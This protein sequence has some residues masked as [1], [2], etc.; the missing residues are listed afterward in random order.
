MSKRINTFNMVIKVVLFILFVACTFNIV[1]AEESVVVSSIEGVSFSDEFQNVLS[2]SNINKYDKDNDGDLSSEELS[3][4]NTISLDLSGISISDW[5]DLNYFNVPIKLEIFNADFS[6]VVFKNISGN[7][8][9]FNISIK[10]CTNIEKLN[11]IDGFPFLTHLAI[12]SEEMVS[13]ESFINC[14]YLEVLDITAPEITK[15]EYLSEL[16]RIRSMQI[17]SDCLNQLGLVFPKIS[18][19]KE[20]SISESDLKDIPGINNLSLDSLYAYHNRISYVM[21]HVMNGAKSIDLRYND[22]TDIEWYDEWYNLYGLKYSK[23]DK[24]IDLRHNPLSNEAI[25]RILDYNYDLSR[26]ANGAEGKELI[27]IYNSNSP[28]RWL[29][30]SKLRFDVEDLSIVEISEGVV[31]YKKPGETNVYVYYDN[32]VSEEECCVIYPVKVEAAYE[33]VAPTETIVPTPTEV[34]D[35]VGDVNKD[36][37]IDAVDALIVLQMAAKLVEI[38]VDLADITEEGKVNAEDALLILKIAAK[39]E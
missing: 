30:L 31:K 21:P 1:K 8:Y 6:E 12:E 37:Y 3:Q 33:T 36:G 27:L 11:S 16:E 24:N 7:C 23:I 13:C 22:I 39:I 20:L 14:K 35:L 26:I 2:N 25:G 32:G 5:S 9:I 38:N 18:T 10:N 4:I 28:F 15:I 19:L 17:K 29:T 34:L